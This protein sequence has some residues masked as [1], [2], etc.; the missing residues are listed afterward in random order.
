M[1][2]TTIAALAMAAMPQQRMVPAKTSFDK[3]S[4]TGWVFVRNDPLKYDPKTVISYEGKVVGVIQGASVSLMVKVKGGAISVVDLGP[5]SYYDAQ[6]MHVMVKDAIK[7]K[8]SKV[9]QE[10]RGTVL[11]AEVVHHG[12]KIAFRSPDGKPFWNR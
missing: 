6:S 11:A 12:S 9:V 8:G 7:V 1:V 3:A 2:L 10:G 5:K 4:D